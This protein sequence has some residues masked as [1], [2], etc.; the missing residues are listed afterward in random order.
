MQKV[1]Y[2]HNNDGYN[3]QHNEEEQAHNASISCNLIKEPNLVLS[4]L[5][6]FSKI[7]KTHKKEEEC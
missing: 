6:T 3:A 2:L 7:K 1:C 5:W 4:I